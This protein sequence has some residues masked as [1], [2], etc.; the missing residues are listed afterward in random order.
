MDQ[1]TVDDEFVAHDILTH[2]RT[3]PRAEAPAA[4]KDANE[5]LN[6]VRIAGLAREV[7]RRRARCVIKDSDDSLKGAA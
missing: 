1:Q 7:A 4:Y 2:C 6:S 5:G 3:Y